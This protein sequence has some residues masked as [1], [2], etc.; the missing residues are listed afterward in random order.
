MSDVN[1]AVYF[2]GPASMETPPRV[3]SVYSSLDIGGASPPV[4]PQGPLAYCQ[5]CGKEGDAAKSVSN[6]QRCN[7]F[8]C[9]VMCCVGQVFFVWYLSVA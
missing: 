1:Q 4:V 3:S 6:C 9:V 8:G 7:F 5:V 2:S